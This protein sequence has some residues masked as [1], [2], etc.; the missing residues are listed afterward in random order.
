VAI[1]QA[2]VDT[3]VAGFSSTP[4]YQAHVMGDRLISPAG[5][6]EFPTPPTILEGFAR[7]TA[8]TPSGFTLQVLLPP[9]STVDAYIL[10]PAGAVTKALLDRLQ[11]ELAWHV[12]WMGVER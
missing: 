4:S 1:L 5:G 6:G 11:G 12:V 3:S 2:T 7:V 10:N 8:A 9:A